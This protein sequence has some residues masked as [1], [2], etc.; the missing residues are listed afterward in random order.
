MKGYRIVLGFS[1]QGTGEAVDEVSKRVETLF[2]HGW[3]LSG[4]H[5]L[6]F[7]REEMEWVAS[8]AMTHPD[9]KL[10]EW[11]AAHPEIEVY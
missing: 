6:R 5:T 7:D 3:V 1:A 9:L 11:I 8:Q 2:D 4:A 10:N